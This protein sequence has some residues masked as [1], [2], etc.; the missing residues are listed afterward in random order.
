M[1]KANISNLN[2]SILYL[3]V[4]MLELVTVHGADL[5]V[6]LY[7][8]M[9]RTVFLPLMISK[10][11]LEFEKPD[12]VFA[13]NSPRMEKS[14]VMSARDL[15]IKNFQIN[16]LYGSEAV[17]IVSKN[18]I[19]MND[20]VKK[21]IELIRKNNLFVLGQPA[22]E[23]SYNVVNKISKISVKRKA[24][25]SPDKIVITF[26]TQQKVIKD[27]SGKILGSGSNER[28][29]NVYYD[30]F[31]RLK[32]HTLYDICI[33]THPNQNPS[34]YNS[35][36]KLAKHLNPILSSYESIQISDIIIIQD[37]TIGIE[38]LISK[39]LVFTFGAPGE[40]SPIW[41]RAPFHYFSNVEDLFNAIIHFDKFRCSHANIVTLPKKSA[42][43]IK[44]LLVSHL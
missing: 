36:F 3:G 28:I 18:I 4:S 10:R 17:N 12:I 31:S 41:E 40:L 2:E 29:I 33:R 9:G 8:E 26:F 30:L 32:N 6:Q 22:L 25:V 1:D 19:V 11:I 39:K 24:S 35:L 42:R 38:A 16:D 37:S 21:E 15:N 44:E 27:E 7:N 43:S 5:A 20:F 23:A 14:I 13:T 34:E